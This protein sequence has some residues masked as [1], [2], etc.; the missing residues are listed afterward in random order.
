MSARTTMLTPNRRLAAML[1]KIDRQHQINNGRK[2]WI[3]PDILP[4]NNWFQRL[5]NDYL[6]QYALASP[7]LLTS[8]IYSTY[9]S[10][11][12]IKNG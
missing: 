4:I 5:F 12:T 11:A 8:F 3:T 7:L 6:N 2:A 10:I 9:L 1:H